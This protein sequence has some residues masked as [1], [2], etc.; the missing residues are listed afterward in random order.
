[1][2]DQPDDFTLPTSAQLRRQV[3]RVEAERDEARREA[4][5]LQAVFDLQYTRTTEAEQRWRA[6]DPEAR[7]HMAPDLGRLLTWLMADADNQRAT[8]GR[9]RR[10]LLRAAVDRDH[11]R[12]AGEAYR[13]QY[14]RLVNI[15]WLLLDATDR[16]EA[17]DVRGHLVTLRALLG[18][19]PEAS[20]DGNSVPRVAQDS[21]TRE[22]HQTGSEDVNGGHSEERVYTIR[23]IMVYRSDDHGSEIDPDVKASAP[24]HLNVSD[25]GA[26]AHECSR[27]TERAA[28]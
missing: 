3:A 4:E 6:E 24:V 12:A 14:S 9:L 21:V 1:M 20:T 18:K 17:L 7:A 8:V 28:P 15:G 11:A 16:N 27:C 22:S 5:E 26:T 25:V 19:R 10:E 2:T 13:R 23:V